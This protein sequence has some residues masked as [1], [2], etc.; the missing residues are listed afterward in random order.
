MTKKKDHRKTLSKFFIFHLAL[1]DIVF[2]ILGIHELIAKRVSHGVLSLSHCKIIVL[3]QYTC[4][5]VLFVL[6]AGIALDRSINIIRPLQ[7]FKNSRYS[8]YCHRKRN[9]ALIWIY[10]LSISAAFIYSA[11]TRRFTRQFSRPGNSSIPNITNNSSELPEHL[12]Y[13]SPR[14]HCVAGP[15]AALRSQIAFTIYFVCGFFLPLC[16]MI[17]CY[18]KVFNFLSNRAKHSMLNH[19][20]VRSK[21]KT[22]SILFNITGFQLPF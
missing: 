12:T 7:S 21:M 16:I 2:R 13:T 4:E 17:I 6:L 11:T 3:F 20:V 10:A 22:V 8:G 18:T 14:V 15:R 19:S 1:A 9:V 5:A